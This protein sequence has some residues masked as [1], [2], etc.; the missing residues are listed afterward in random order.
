MWTNDDIKAFESDL[1]LDLE[2]AWT[3]GLYAS[4]V[5]SQFR[6][7]YVEFLQKKLEDELQHEIRDYDLANSLM[8]LMNG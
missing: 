7:P 6:R 2:D 1:Q 8:R 3:H 5:E 4:E